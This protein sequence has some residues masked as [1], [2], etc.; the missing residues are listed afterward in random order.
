MLN[1]TDEKFNIAAKITFVSLE[2]IVSL[3]SI[4]INSIVIF[5][6]IKEPKLRRKTNLYIISLVTV[7]FLSGL[8]IIPFGI[9]RVSSK[10][11][12]KILQY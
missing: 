2:T 6:F 11:I 10:I 12:S 8:L 4:F 1:Q 7:D 9:F 3:I 5:A